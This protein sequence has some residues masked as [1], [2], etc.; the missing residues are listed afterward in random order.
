MSPRPDGIYFDVS[1]EEYDESPRDNFSTVKLFAKSPAHFRHEKL[2]AR[3]KKKGKGGD[4]PSKLFGRCEHLAVF[5]PDDFARRVAVWDG[6]RRGKLWKKFAAENASREILKEPEYQK[7]LTIQKMVRSHPVAGPLCRGGKFE[8]TIYWTYRSPAVGALDAWEIQMK[9]RID[10]VS[11]LGLTDLKTARDA[12][13]DGFGRAAWNYFYPAQVAC[14]SDAYFSITGRRLP[15][16]FIAAETAE[17]FEVQVYT[18][19]DWQLALGREQYTG[20]LSTLHACRSTS[21][22]PGYSEGELELQLPRWAVPDQA[23]DPTGLD[24]EMGE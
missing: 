19:P 13:P 16:R 6:D 1:R 5:E 21:T 10:F 20:W 7:A 2:N 22:Y 18:V 23:D 12:S 4:T 8:V 17:P 3:K 11:E 24:L 14:Y 15:S 9:S